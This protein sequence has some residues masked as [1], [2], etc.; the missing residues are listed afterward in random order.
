MYPKCLSNVTGLD[1]QK[2]V[3][4]ELT[5]VCAPVAEVLLQFAVTIFYVPLGSHINIC[6]TAVQYK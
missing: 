6:Q 2:Q 1:F 5:L 3:Y 4:K